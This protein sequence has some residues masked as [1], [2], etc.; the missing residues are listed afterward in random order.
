M[1]PRRGV[2][3]IGRTAR[4]STQG[5]HHF[6]SQPAER[7]S[8]PIVDQEAHSSSACLPCTSNQGS[9]TTGS[10]SA[11]SRLVLQVD[12]SVYLVND[13]AVC[14]ALLCSSC[15]HAETHF[16]C[17]KS[18]GISYQSPVILFDHLQI[19]GQAQQT[20]CESCLFALQFADSSAHQRHLL[21]TWKDFALHCTRITGIL[22]FSVCKVSMI[23]SL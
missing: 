20:T 19:G 6:I 11:S 14:G 10:H 1:R 7:Y 5:A 23:S 8:L 15:Q 17:K 4:T 2:S 9:A 21:C 12:K 13:S 22:N 16:L 18:P 3:R